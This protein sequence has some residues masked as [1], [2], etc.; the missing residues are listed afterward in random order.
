MCG[1]L[2]DD[3]SSAGVSRFKSLPECRV[4]LASVARIEGRHLGIIEP[5]VEKNETT[6]G[7]SYGIAQ[8][9]CHPGLDVVQI[10]ILSDLSR[11]PSECSLC[12]EWHQY[13]GRLLEIVALAANAT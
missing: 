1:A 5:D 6:T 9:V 10:P 4:L 7:A 11:F 2:G 3:D 8:R 13:G 12:D